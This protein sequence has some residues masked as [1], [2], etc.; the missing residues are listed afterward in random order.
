LKSKVAIYNN[1]AR[2]I[3]IEAQP[4]KTINASLQLRFSDKASV[5]AFAMHEEVLQ[6]LRQGVGWAI[7]L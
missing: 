3:L 4:A 6:K 5:V 1:S 2:R 7:G